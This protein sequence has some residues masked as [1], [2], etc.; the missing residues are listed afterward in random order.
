V[1]ICGGEEKFGS[2]CFRYCAHREMV[3]GKMVFV[4][5]FEG[6]VPQAIA[7]TCLGFMRQNC[8]KSVLLACYCMPMHCPS[9]SVCPASAY[10]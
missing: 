6:A 5:Y 8:N 10:S 1:P 7:S 4:R 3:G 9:V 2:S